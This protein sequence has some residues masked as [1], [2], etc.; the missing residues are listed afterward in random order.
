MRKQVTDLEDEIFKK[1]FFTN[2]LSQTVAK[3]RKKIGYNRQLIQQTITSKMNKTNRMYMPKIRKVAFDKKKIL[4]G[5]YPSA[6]DL[7]GQLLVGSRR[8]KSLNFGTTNKALTLAI[9]VISTL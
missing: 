1:E 2:D 6:Q 3:S 7:Y 8:G 4:Q 9:K 5:E